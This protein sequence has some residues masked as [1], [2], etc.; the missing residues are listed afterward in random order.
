MLSSDVLLYILISLAS[1]VK[2]HQ[3][4]SGRIST[5]VSVLSE[6]VESFQVQNSTMEEALLT[7]RQ[8]D[9]TR[10]L[11]G[12]E[13]IAHWEGEK[14]ESL[15]LSTNSATVG[16]IL[17]QLCQQSMQYQYEFIEGGLIYVHPVH[18]ESDPLGLLNIKITDF[19][20]EGNMAPQ[21]IISRI[22]ELAPEL[23]AYLNAKKGEYYSRRGIVPGFPGSILH[24]NLDPE[25]NLHLQNMTV[26]EI[27]NAV[28]LY[29]RQLSAQ[30]PADI[31]GNKIPP[32]SWMY[33][34][35]L[36]PVA[37]TGLG[38]IPRWVAF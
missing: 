17:Q 16:E 38:G 6:I 5:D 15:S 26:R 1:T 19:S 2:P 28:V 37:P 29:S 9:F 7:L 18:G 22:G 31:G 12:F 36:N 11:I 3:E 35:V 30:T 20:V 27:L 14:T 23:A 21:A 4:S 33:E 25:V 8:R 32:T 13:K 10:I 34:F 24:G